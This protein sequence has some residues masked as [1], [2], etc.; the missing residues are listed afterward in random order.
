M[1]TARFKESYARIANFEK[2]KNIKMLGN[3]CLNNMLIQKHANINKRLI[4]I[5]I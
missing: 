4:K 1:V 5:I 3:K 2:I